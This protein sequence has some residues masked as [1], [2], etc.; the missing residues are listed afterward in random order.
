MTNRSRQDIERELSEAR[1][2]LTRTWPTETTSF[3]MRDA[4]SAEARE[5]LQRVVRLQNELDAL[6]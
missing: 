4:P 3:S 5:A 2:E 1:G 6:D